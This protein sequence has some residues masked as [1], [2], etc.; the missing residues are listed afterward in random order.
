MATLTSVNRNSGSLTSSNKS[1]IETE[2]V[3]ENLHTYLVGA[4]ESLTLVTIDGGHGISN[5]N[6]S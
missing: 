2:F 6:K 5:I 3:D 1:L 4:S